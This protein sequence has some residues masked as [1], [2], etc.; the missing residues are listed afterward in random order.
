MGRFVAS[1]QDAE[2]AAG[3]HTVKVSGADRAS[4][5]YFVR[6]S[7]DDFLMSGKLLLLK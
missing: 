6:M 7:A 5:V 2:V 4:G 1:L 3:Y